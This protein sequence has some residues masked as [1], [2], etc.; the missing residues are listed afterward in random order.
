M[1]NF[2][3]AQ[4]MFIDARINEIMTQAAEPGLTVGQESAVDERVKKGIDTLTDPK[5]KVLDDERK[6]LATAHNADIQKIQADY[7]QMG[8]K[9]DAMLTDVDQ[10]ATK[11]INSLHEVSAK[12]ETGNKEHL[13][14]LEASIASH[15]A[16]I[17]AARA[18]I[19]QNT[20]AL[21][22]QQDSNDAPL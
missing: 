15:R 3:A 18:E 19:A 16:F 22:E 21:K 12:V 20:A 9:L 5:L 10:R 2:D 8:I 6:Q 1:A 4:L 17:D 13:D 11:H 14:T 7:I